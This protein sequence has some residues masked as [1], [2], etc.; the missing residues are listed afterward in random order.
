MNTS[1]RHIVVGVFSGQPSD[2][3]KHAGRFAH[4]FSADLVCAYVEATR[5]VAE[6]GPDGAIF[7]LPIDPDLVDLREEVV[8]PKLEAEIAHG[9]D[10]QDVT[11][12][13]RALAGDPAEALAHLADQLDAVLIIVGTRE[14]GIRRSLHEFFNGSVGARLAHRQHRPVVIIPLNPVATDSELPWNDA[15]AE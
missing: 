14:P 13:V 10:G 4:Q 3:V 1:E 15:N 7:S 8:D 12:T 11:W 5:F 6:E 2:V 9:L